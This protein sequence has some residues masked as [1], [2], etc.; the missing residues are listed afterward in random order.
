MILSTLMAIVF[1]VTA[2]IFFQFAA[3]QS[4]SHL[5]RIICGLL[6]AAAVVL[7]VAASCDGMRSPIPPPSA[8]P[9][10]DREA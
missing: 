4:V 8:R 3:D 7:A 2:W 10:E 9:P 5:A 6:G 1:A